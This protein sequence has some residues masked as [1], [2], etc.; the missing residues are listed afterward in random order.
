[1]F[2]KTYQGTY[3]IK[4]PHKYS[5]D[6]D[7]VVYR[8]A[9]ERACFVWCERN[10]SV[11]EWNSEET[12]IEYYDKASKKLRR[13]FIDLTIK[14]K[15]GTTVLVEVKPNRQTK[16]PKKPERRTKKRTQRYLQETATYITNMCKWEAA[17]KFAT[18]QGWSFEVWDENILKQKGILKF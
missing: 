11:E 17:S 1:M 9:W 13:Y 10:N 18:R 14:F 12:V 7:N 2:K 16:S 4:K 15:D 8:S 3:K 6:A 5:G